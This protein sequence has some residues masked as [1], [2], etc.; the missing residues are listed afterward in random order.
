[1]KLLSK[2]SV[3]W[4]ETE[5]KQ[6]GTRV[7]LHN[8]IWEKFAHRTLRDLGHKRVHIKVGKAVK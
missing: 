2:T 7:A 5:Q 1:M 6:F 3:K 8:F 4:F